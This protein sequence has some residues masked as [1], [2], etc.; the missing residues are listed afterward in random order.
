MCWGRASAE[1]V[2]RAAQSDHRRSA[3]QLLTPG[4]RP[5]THGDRPWA[6]WNADVPREIP[7]G[8]RGAGGR[9]TTAPEVAVVVPVQPAITGS[10]LL[11]GRCGLDGYVRFPG[12]WVAIPIPLIHG[13]EKVSGPEEFRPGDL[14]ESAQA[15]MQKSF[16]PPGGGPTLPSARN[17]PAME[18]AAII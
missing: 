2:D 8:F 7:G 15:A 10:R 6:L 5:E 4:G 18:M 17:S 9:G 3:T 11:T 12:R 16:P 1:G 13:N 14:G